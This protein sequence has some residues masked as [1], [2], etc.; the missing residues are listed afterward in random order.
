MELELLLSNLEDGRTR[1]TIDGP[2]EA[3]VM[4]FMGLAGE[5]SEAKPEEGGLDVGPGS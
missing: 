1:L 3:V 2:E 5:L 4:I